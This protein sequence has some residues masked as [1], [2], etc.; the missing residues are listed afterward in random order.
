[1]ETLYPA[2]FPDNVPIA[3]IKKISLNKLLNDAAEEAQ[4]MFDV[5][6]DTGFFYLDMMD[7]DMGRKLWE[8]AC[9]AARSGIENFPNT[10]LAEKKLSKAPAGVKVLER[11]AAQSTKMAPLI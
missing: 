10:P 7:H 8:D 4:K 5:C 9:V 6:K 1:M 3:D 2:P 11:G